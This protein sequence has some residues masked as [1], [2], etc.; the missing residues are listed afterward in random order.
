MEKGGRRLVDLVYSSQRLAIRKLYKQDHH[1]Q[2]QYKTSE[3]YNVLCTCTHSHLKIE[4]SKFL[5]QK[6]AVSIADSPRG[7]NIIYEHRNA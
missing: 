1:L 7:G 2:L 4:I 6:R 3:F 5:L